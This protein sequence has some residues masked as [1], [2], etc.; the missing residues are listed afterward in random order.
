M[1]DPLIARFAQACGA[2][3]PLDLRI[4]L[5]GGGPLAEGTVEQ[6]FTLV[7]R[8]DACDVTLT[9]PDINPRHAWL[10]VIGGR[11]FVADLGSRTGVL[12]P[13][14][15]RGS[16][17]LEPGAPARLGP[18]LLHLRAGAGSPG[19]STDGYNPLAADPAMKAKP[20]AA[21][22][23][24]NGRRHKD[25]WH[26]NRLVTLIGRAPDCKIHLNA[27]D[28]AAYHCGIVTTPD[29]LWVV[30]LSGL[31]VVV[32]GERMR[33]SLLPHG[34]ELWVG[35]FL[36]GCHSPNPAAIA[37]RPAAAR[38]S[39]AIA[40]APERP[41]P[42]GALAVPGPPRRGAQDDEVDF[43]T[44]P[45]GLGLP[46]SHIMADIFRDAVPNAN[47]PNSNPI[48]L[49]GAG[50]KTDPQADPEPAA[51]PGAPDDPHVAD[52]WPVV[53]LLRQMADIHARADAE[54]QQSLVLVA[55]AF[56]RV[57]PEHVPALRHDLSRIVEVTAEIAALRAEVARTALSA[58]ANRAAAA[59][60]DARTGPWVPASSNTPMPEPRDPTGS[61]AAER[62]AALQRDRAER[63]QALLAL[64]AEQ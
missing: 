64:F 33:V 8:D 59:A 56:G 20:T 52:D 37:A 43:A 50:P 14:G 31:G 46:A 35:R 57:R 1:T 22:E 45:D 53:P 13:N 7:G 4:D 60:G 48:L 23:F 21:L 49:S 36:I 34:A 55:Q 29:G 11:V 25:R 30:D 16:G 2:T 40:P 26:I 17:W 18:F 39:G 10:Q 62:L 6:P 38:T 63:W 5:A 12:W 44:V 28:I 15:S 19:G 24:R 27:D 9:D 51:A 3:G 58:A 32:N 41:A 47:G 42:A 61:R 54:F